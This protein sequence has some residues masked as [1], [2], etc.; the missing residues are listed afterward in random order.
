MDGSEQAIWSEVRDRRKLIRLHPGVV[1]QDSIAFDHVAMP[2]AEAFELKWE[3][4]IAV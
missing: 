1:S 4:R 3:G 2:R